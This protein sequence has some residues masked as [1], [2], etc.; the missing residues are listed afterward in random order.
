MFKVIVMAL[1][2]AVFFYTLRTKLVDSFE[3]PI[4]QT[5]D[6]KKPYDDFYAPVYG[7]MISD[8][9]KERTAYE[10]TDLV[11]KTDLDQYQNAKLLD[12][13]CGGGDHLKLLS[14]KDLPNVELV[15]IDKSEAM[16]RQTKK[17]IGK[18]LDAAPVRLLKKDV[19]EHDLFM[20]SSFSHITCYYF[21]VYYLDSKKIIP[22]IKYW[23]RPKGWFVV[24]LVDLDKFDPVLDAASP[25]VGID[26]QKYVKTRITDSTIHF[27]KFVY[28][29]NFSLTKDKA[30]LEETF[31]FK[32]RPT[33]RRQRHILENINVGYFVDQMGKADLELKYT[34]NLGSHGYHN[35][36]ILYFQKG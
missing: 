17:R 29:S 35:Q 24:H 20:R 14:Q 4:S 33:I 2:L 32:G 36:Y 5:I 15:G 19:Y 28:R 10:V 3:N 34:T 9:I 7:T 21:T 22:Q 18:P 23:L 31:D 8:Q 26:P 27:K 1:A 11:S 12:L 25:F 30:Q 13:G 6:A 16:L